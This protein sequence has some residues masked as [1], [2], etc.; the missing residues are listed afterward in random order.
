MEVKIIEKALWKELKLHFSHSYPKIHIRMQASFLKDLWWKS[1]SFVS[2]GCEWELCHSIFWGILKTFQV[3]PFFK[4]GLYLHHL[5]RRIN[6]SSVPDTLLQP[7]QLIPLVDHRD[8]IVS[9][10][11]NYGGKTILFPVQIILCI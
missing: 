9:Y 11:R 10:S 5:W 4:A 1:A 3:H 8:H 7:S 2:Q 6:A